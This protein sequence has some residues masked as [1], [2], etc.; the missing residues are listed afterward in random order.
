MEDSFLEASGRPEAIIITFPCIEHFNE[1]L[2][3]TPPS[4]DLHQI[5]EAGSYPVSAAK[6]AEIN[7][8]E[9]PCLWR[10]QLQ[11]PALG[12][13][14]G[15]VSLFHRPRLPS[16]SMSC[17]G[18][19]AGLGDYRAASLAMGKQVVRETEG[20]SGVNETHPSSHIFSQSLSG[21]H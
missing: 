12:R 15:K 17:S 19:S 16:S 2:S 1:M 4:S 3:Q 6:Q 8:A 14:T 5:L 18:S 20:S 10:P 13:H 9:R 21:I 11:P 7:V